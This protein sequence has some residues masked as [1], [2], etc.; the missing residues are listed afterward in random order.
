MLCTAQSVTSQINKNL[1]KD[2]ARFDFE[3]Y[4]ATYEKLRNPTFEEN[5]L[6][7]RVL[8]RLNKFEDAL[9]LITKIE[10]T[11]TIN[12]N[13]EIL[14]KDIQRILEIQNGLV[15]FNI[16]EVD[17][18]S[19]NTE[20][21]CA[22]KDGKLFYATDNVKQLSIQ[23]K[24]V[25][26]N[27]AYLN[28]EAI[29]INGINSSSLSQEVFS[30]ETLNDGPVA[31][32]DEM[33]AIT[34]NYA[35]EK[36]K[37]L[38]LVF[39]SENEQKEFFYNDPSYSVGHAT[40]SE[41]GDTLI[42][43][44]DM[45]NKNGWTD[46]FYCVKNDSNWSKPIKLPQNINTKG[47]EMFPKLVG[48]IL[49]FS[50]NGHQGVGQLDIY[51]VNWLV[52]NAEPVLLPF[53][54]NSVHDDLGVVFEKQISAGYF[55]SNRKGSD[56]IYYFDQSVITFDC[57]S[58]CK[59]D[60]CVQ[61][62]IEDF[63][64]FDDSRFAFVWDFGDGENGEGAYVTH[65]YKDTGEYFVQL[66]Y[67]DKL[68]GKFLNGVM[69]DTIVVKTTTKNL[70]SFIL[71][72]SLDI[73][74]TYKIKDNSELNS[75]VLAVSAWDLNGKISMVDF[76][77]LS[78]KNPGY[79]RITRHVKVS[80]S[81]CCYQSFYDYVY[82]KSDNSI[83]NLKIED[84]IGNNSNQNLIALHPIQI[85]VKDPNENVLSDYQMTLKSNNGTLFY[86]GS[87]EDT[88]TVL[89]DLSKEY[90]VSA[91]TEKGNI[92]NMILSLASRTERD[93]LFIYQLENIGKYTIKTV[94][95][96]GMLLSNVQL[97]CEDSVVGNTN[98]N[99]YLTL[100]DL[101][102]Q[103]ITFNKYLYFEETEDLANMLVGDTLIVTLGKIEV[104]AVFRLEDI[105][106]DL[107]KWN[108]RPDAAVE[109]D[110]LVAIM[111]KYPTL[112][113]ELR[114]HTDSRGSDAFN[115]KLSDK[116]AKSA[117]AYIVAKGIEINRLQGKGYGETL[118]LNE[119]GDGVKCSSEQHQWNRRVECKILKI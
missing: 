44:S 26:T 28:I 114:A 22:Y 107:N 32:F 58:A 46:L 7:A 71:I 92:Q 9:R 20:F 117:A 4:L 41:T 102:E 2:W 27:N 47:N 96:R 18:N 80:D 10:L 35:D 14:K 50:S 30:G 65:C 54:I 118:L 78:F 68:T 115:E 109:L 60:P 113:I 40:F 72:D 94:D 5:E 90:T 11:H 45:E 61:L 108:I 52:E 13:I 105:Y 83:E 93:F 31:F 103:K 33:A 79:K 19:N 87:V 51:K 77:E 56:D 12:E 23:R 111:E 81:N 64:G 6:T 91:F 25:Q 106:F 8:Y 38:R 1:A 84:T 88:L 59:N 82:V 29:E 89:V 74:Q 39:K 67:K 75:G 53:P 85:L 76:P 86:N 37:N 34:L 3:S 99:G 73:N 15:L 48:E 21:T 110:K 42:F 24:D 70:P 57:N 17:F 62:E 100:N 116:R 66:S 101:P 104:D 36:N 98:R 97:F 63:T 49:Y 69:S 119:C 95:E 43:V 16:E 112:E 55:T